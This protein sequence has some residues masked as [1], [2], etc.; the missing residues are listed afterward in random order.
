MPEDPRDTINHLETNDLS[1]QIISSLKKKLAN[2]ETNKVFA[3]GQPQGVNV[4]MATV[5]HNGK[6]YDVVDETWFDEKN[7]QQHDISLVPK[8]EKDLL[9]VIHP[10]NGTIAAIGPDNDL[11]LGHAN[12]GYLFSL[13]TLGKFEENTSIKPESVPLIIEVAQNR[14]S[15]LQIRP[16][17]EP[18]L[19]QKI[20]DQLKKHKSLTEQYAERDEEFLAKEL[21]RLNGLDMREYFLSETDRHAIEG[22]LVRKYGYDAKKLASLK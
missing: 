18:E 6:Q 10:E 9:F 20:S 17:G 1:S 4:K 13:V 22:L 11:Q 12:I 2:L 14:T 5:D 7:A 19:V 15:V 16:G 8:D 21:K 3:K